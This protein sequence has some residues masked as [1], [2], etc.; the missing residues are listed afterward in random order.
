M[1]IRIRRD[2]LAAAT[3]RAFCIWA[4]CFLTI[5]AAPLRLSSENPRYAEFRGETVLLVGSTEHYG[6]VVNLDFDYELYLDE[7]AACGLNLVRV[8]TGAYLETTGSFNIAE[9]S[10]APEPG[11]SL[12][13]WARSDVP[14]AADGGNKY[15]LT[16][17]DAAWFQRLR[18]FVKAAG[19][20]GIVVEV[21]LFCPFYNETLWT[22]SPLHPDNHINGTAPMTRQQVFTLESELLPYQIALARRCA[23]EL[24]GLDN[25]FLEVINEP[26]QGGVPDEWQ[27]RIVDELVDAMPGAATRLLIAQNVANGQAVIA[28]P[29]PDVSIFNFHY[30]VPD[31]VLLNLGLNRLIGDDET[32]FAGPEDFSY[33]KEAWRFLF[34]GGGLVNHLDFS[35]TANSETGLY[36]PQSPGGGGPSL[37][38]QIGIVK[39]FAESL[40]FAQSASLD[41][42]V[43]AG[44]PANGGAAVFGVPGETYALYLWGT[45]G[46]PLAIELPPG[47]YAGRWID[48]RSG[49][50]LVPL[51]S[52]THEEAGPVEF[53]PPDYAEDIVLL[54]TLAEKLPPSVFLEDPAYQTIAPRNADLTLRANV[55]P[56]GGSVES[57]EFFENGKL[58]G[59]VTDPPYEWTL[60]PAERGL[61]RFAAKVRLAD[62]RSAVSPPAKCQIVG[63][64]VDGVNLNGA[65]TTTPGQTWKAN[66]DALAVGMT[67]S[68]ATPLSAG[69]SIGLYPKPG[70]S[71]QPLVT[72]QFQ[73]AQSSTATQLRVDYPLADGHYEI[74]VH[75]VEAVAGYSRDISVFLEGTRATAGIGDLGLGEWVNYGPYRTEVR[76]GVLNLAFQRTFKGV[77]KVASF[78][79]YQAEPPVP[80]AAAKLAVMAEGGTAVLDFPA[81]VDPSRIEMSMTLDGTWQPVGFPHAD[82]GESLRIVVPADEPRRFFRIRTAP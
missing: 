71:L 74:F 35:F 76:D 49:E 61:R 79:I 75:I 2:G 20:R 32:G 58:I 50:T 3:A 47:T 81:S 30:A 17:W 1:S 63:P 19:E 69:G 39:W 51:E 65:E 77:P 8:F 68:Q 31:A 82:H 70:S 14:G 60:V 48:T 72:S 62:G 59:T 42:I 55:D 26:Y 33:R 5:S 46:D 56:A 23:T 44:A 57:V 7:T 28:D 67:V 10:L 27:A 80:P 6:A 45:I 43:T 52:F 9:N 24:A 54:L 34:A 16:K 40:P 38:R 64:F 73:W 4:A 22:I 41:A 66:G 12:V 53:M 78:S 15:D 18:A 29:D 11:R 36:L 37:R 13:P 21:T 25:V